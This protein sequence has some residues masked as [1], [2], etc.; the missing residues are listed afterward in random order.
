[1]IQPYI[2][3]NKQQLPSSN[4]TTTKHY[5]RFK[6]GNIGMVDEWM[7]VAMVMTFEL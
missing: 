2:V 1:M 3:C 4:R 5:T 7:H 6:R